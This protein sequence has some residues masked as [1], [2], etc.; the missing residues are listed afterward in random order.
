VRRAVGGAAGL[1]AA[2][3][4]LGVL[5]GLSGD[6]QGLVVPALEQV[7]GLRLDGAPRVAHVDLL[8]EDLL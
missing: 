1:L 8:D 7:T 6:S 4:A 5:L 3:L 2:S